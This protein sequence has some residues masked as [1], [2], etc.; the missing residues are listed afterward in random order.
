MDLV[1]PGSAAATRGS[2]AEDCRQEPFQVAGG[3]EPVA[4]ERQEAATVT[5]APGTACS[6]T[7]CTP[8]SPEAP[9]SKNPLPASLPGQRAGPEPG[10]AGA[11]GPADVRKRW[12]CESRPARPPS[13]PWA[14]CSVF[15]KPWHPQSYLICLGDPGLIL[16]LQARPPLQDKVWPCP[17]PA[18]APHPHPGFLTQD[19]S[20][21]DIQAF[22]QTFICCSAQ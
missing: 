16:R 18:A 20:S 8:A 21:R 6:W 19:P 14:H 1:A 15:L 12:R 7:P 17:Q 9:G 22:P 2:A 11:R 4:G 13:L 10:K 5:L 3:A